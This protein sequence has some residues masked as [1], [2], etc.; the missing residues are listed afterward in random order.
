MSSET[1]DRFV[2]IKHCLA[3]AEQ[4]F[5]RAGRCEDAVERARLMDE[6]EVWLVRAERAFARVNDRAIPLESGG[7]P[8]HEHRSFQDAAAEEALVWRREAKPES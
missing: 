6:A 3:R 8:L 5:A 1:P 7:R 2:E 4:A